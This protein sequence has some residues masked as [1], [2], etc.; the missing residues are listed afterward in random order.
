MISLFCESLLIIGTRKYLN[1]IFTLDTM[2]VIT[3]EEQW[4][5]SATN[6]K[7]NIKGK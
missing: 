2:E 5:E 6:N 1:F 4:D 7:D 3:K